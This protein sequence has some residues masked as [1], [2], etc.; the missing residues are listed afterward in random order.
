EEY[1]KKM[2]IPN[3]KD[4]LSKEERIEFLNLAWD[5]ATALAG[6]NNIFPKLGTID[7]FKAVFENL[8]Y[9]EIIREIYEAATSTEIKDEIIT[10]EK[11][12][13]IRKIFQRK[14]F[15]LKGII[16][17]KIVD[18]RIVILRKKETNKYAV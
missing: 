7:N 11:W 4:L 9:R 6:A 2:K 10:D 5:F 17:F 15:E 16:N 13:E 8:E 18:F 1:I 14:A 12:E 3:R